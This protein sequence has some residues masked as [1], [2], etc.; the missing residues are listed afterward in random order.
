MDDD[1]DDDSELPRLTME[2]QRAAMENA[3]YVSTYALR[4]IFAGVYAENNPA[5]LEKLKGFSFVVIAF[6][7][8]TG[9]TSHV[10]SLPQDMVIN[11][12]HWI[13]GA[14]R[15]VCVSKEIPVVVEDGKVELGQAT[16][17]ETSRDKMN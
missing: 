4:K 11:L 5:I 7:H 10:S 16:A 12:M 14:G 9:M 2:Q 3:S 1:S 17:T 8:N 15:E 6:D 13:T